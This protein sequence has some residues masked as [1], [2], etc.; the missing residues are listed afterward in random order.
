M[1]MFELE[2]ESVEKWEKT[3][4]YNTMSSVENTTRYSSR[5]LFSDYV[6]GNLQSKGHLLIFT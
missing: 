5:L 2:I 6:Y 4:G 1:T 3:E